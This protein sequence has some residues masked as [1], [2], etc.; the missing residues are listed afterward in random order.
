MP[1]DGSD[2]S[3]RRRNWPSAVQHDAGHPTCF[4]RSATYDD[5]RLRPI[6]LPSCLLD[7]IVPLRSI[8]LIRADIS[9]IRAILPV[10]LK[11]ASRC[12]CNHP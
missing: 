1:D 10:L 12:N 9:S 3:L 6:P 5:H 2:R 4:A 7:Y 11:E 8:L